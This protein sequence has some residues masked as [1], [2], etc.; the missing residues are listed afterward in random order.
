MEFITEETALREELLSA[1]ER[2]KTACSAEPWEEL[3]RE[4]QPS[5]PAGDAPVTVSGQLPLVPYGE[6]L[7]FFRRFLRRLSRKSVR[8]YTD[9][10]LEQQNRV[11]R[12]LLRRIEE[13]ETRVREL[14]ERP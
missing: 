13:L 6:E 2:E 8:W 1:A 9:G 10:L 12:A 3:R 5:S 11:N 14:E 4:F 7:G